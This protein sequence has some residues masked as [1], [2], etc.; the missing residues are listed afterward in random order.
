MPSIQK[1]RGSN[2]R[3]A[4]FFYRFEL[5]LIRNVEG[6]MVDK[7]V[8]SNKDVIFSFGGYIVNMTSAN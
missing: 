7:E 6:A 5:R 2:P 3:T 8:K 1:V 4:E